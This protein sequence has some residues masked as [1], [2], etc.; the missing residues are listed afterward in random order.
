MKIVVSGPVI[1]SNNNSRT[2]IID[3][4][5]SIMKTQKEQTTE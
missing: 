3:K 4:S 5:S 2:I 1:D